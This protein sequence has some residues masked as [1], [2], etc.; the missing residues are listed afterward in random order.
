MTFQASDEK[1]RHFLNLAND[2]YKD[3]EP[4]Y[5]KDGPWLQALDIWTYYALV[6]QELLQIMPQ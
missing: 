6:L 1:G 3:I 2:N 5:I 4:S